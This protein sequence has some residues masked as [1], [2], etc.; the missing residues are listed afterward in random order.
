MTL[1]SVELLSLPSMGV[2]AGEAPWLAALQPGDD[3]RS[4]SRWSACIKCC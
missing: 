1:E 2:R 3:A 4:W